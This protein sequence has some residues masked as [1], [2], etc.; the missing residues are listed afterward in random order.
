MIAAKYT[1]TTGQCIY[2]K[3]LGGW[4]KSAEVIPG[5]QGSYRPYGT[6]YATYF[7]T[8]TNWTSNKDT[9]Y[10]IGLITLDRN[11]GNSTGW[12]GYAYYSSVNGLTGHL[13][14]YPT[15]KDSGLYS[16]YDYGSIAS[17]TSY[18]LYYQID[19]SI[20][21]SGSGIYRI[22]DNKRY[23]FGVHGY[24]STSSSTYNS[25]TRIDSNK[26]NDLKSWINSGT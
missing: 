12:L 5:L 25:G 11:I 14:G 10:D 23:V 22:Y 19:T 13:A 17:S 24:G 8:Y 1:L 2:D 15:D 20:G 9:N 18:R 4:A 3:S 26:F 21:Q 7:R 16:Y 6:A